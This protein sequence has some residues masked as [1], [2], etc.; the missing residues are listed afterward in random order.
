MKER[1]FVHQFIRTHGAQTLTSKAC[2]TARSPRRASTSRWAVTLQSVVWKVEEKKCNFKFDLFFIPQKLQLLASG[3][4]QLS[5]LCMAPECKVH[6]FWTIA[7][8]VTKRLLFAYFGFHCIVSLKSNQ[9]DRMR[10]QNLGSLA[11]YCVFILRT[12]HFVTSF[13]QALTNTWSL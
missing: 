12:D 1:G 2:S 11:I 4:W 10:K 13:P 8:K 3:L 5:H 9:G 7:I 6:I